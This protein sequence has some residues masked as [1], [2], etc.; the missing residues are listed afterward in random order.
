MSTLSA[1]MYRRLTTP[2][3]SAVASESHTAGI[4]GD[5]C[6]CFCRTTP[7]PVLP[8]SDWEC[9]VCALSTRRQS[10]I[11][12]GFKRYRVCSLHQWLSERSYAVSYY[13]FVCRRR[14]LLLRF[15]EHGH[16]RTPT[17]RGYKPFVS[18]G[19]CG[20]FYVFSRQNQVF[21][22]HTPEGLHPAPCLSFMKRVLPFVHTPS[23]R[24]SSLTQN[25]LAASHE[26]PTCKIRRC[27]EHFKR[28][29]R[30][31]WS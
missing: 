13:V 8:L 17:S 14:R 10:T 7:G 31:S 2:P 9:S 22:F 15:P 6:R 24:V 28:F 5:I 12:I 19:S 25:L 30:R 4:S 18:V 20:W 27:T 1:A 26:I 23:S 29:S 3:G 21:T 16:H 11:M